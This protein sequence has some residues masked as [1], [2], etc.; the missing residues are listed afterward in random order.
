LGFELL[1]VAT[2][3]GSDG[4]RVS[5]SGVPVLDALGPVGGGAHTPDEYIEIASV[6]ERGAL[7]AALIARLARTDG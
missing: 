7:V 5:G 4:N 2:G 6:P 1:D 3:G